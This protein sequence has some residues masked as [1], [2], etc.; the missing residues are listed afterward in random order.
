MAD[1][2]RIELARDLFAAWS[3]GDADRPAAYLAE[4]AVLYDIVG[5]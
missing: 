2:P 3:S 5:G 4:D 1:D